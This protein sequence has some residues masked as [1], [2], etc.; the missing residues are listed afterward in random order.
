[1]RAPTLSRML[2]LGRLLRR[3]MAAAA[4]LPVGLAFAAPPL[5]D[6][7]PVARMPAP[8]Q[9]Q[10][11][12]RDARDRG[13]LWR[14][15][16]EGRTSWLYGTVHVARVG[17]SVPGPT[18][19]AA[20]RA[21]DSLA[22]ELNLLD[23]A[24]MKVLQ[25][26]LQA[27]PDA[28]PLPEDLASRLQSQLRA[29]CAAPALDSLRP[30]AQVMSLMALA[31]RRAG[32]DPAYGIDASLA[33]TA[34]ALG[35]PVIG[36]ETPE[37]Q[38]RELVSDDPERVI[39]SVKTGLGQLERGSAGSLLT[40][41]TQAWA[42]GRLNLLETLPEWCD[43]VDSEAERADYERS[44]YGRNPGIAQAMAQQ[45][46]AGRSIFTAVGSLHMVG[47]IGLPA[48]LQAEGFKVQRVPLAPPGQP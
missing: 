21:S 22:L 6:C 29:A 31:G 24:V 11:L 20:L 42:D 7:P 30:D 34:M 41:I 13:V 35:K 23:P 1:M 25:Q 15:E 18:V 3:A 48:L 28:P 16:H 40:R 38:L 8:A 46:R 36:L 27:R 47:P 9:L 45:L 2:G 26:G 10:A 33:G 12:L 14:V 44:I 39:Q 37:R 4:L 43:C 19:M 5:A 32:L 17:W